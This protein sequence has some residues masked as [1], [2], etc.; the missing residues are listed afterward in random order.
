MT[1]IMGQATVPSNSTVPLFQIP[2]GFVSVTMYNINTSTVFLGTSA[3]VSPTN[4][5]VMHSVPTSFTGS[6]T[7]KAAMIYGANTAGTGT[8]INYI[9]DSDQ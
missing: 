2:P 1:L 4:G 5:L 8:S 3:S 6:M 7:S 9:I